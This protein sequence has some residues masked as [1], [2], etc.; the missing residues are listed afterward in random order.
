MAAHWIAMS[1]SK[2]LSLS[3]VGTYITVLLQTTKD[4]SVLLIKLPSVDK[5]SDQGIRATSVLLAILRVLIFLFLTK[6]I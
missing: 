1:I 3:S 5:K 2:I 6:S 4:T